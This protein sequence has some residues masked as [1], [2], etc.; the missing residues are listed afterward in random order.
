MEIR[1]IRLSFLVSVDVIP[2][3]TDVQKKY[4]SL[5]SI[6]TK[7]SGKEVFHTNELLLPYER[8]VKLHAL[9]QENC[10]YQDAVFQFK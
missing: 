6:G 3:C 10:T 7:W 5:S 4:L 8:K 2:R 9:E 1:K